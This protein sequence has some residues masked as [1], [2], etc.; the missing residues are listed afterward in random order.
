MSK[1]LKKIES[2]IINMII[3]RSLK[4]RMSQF[5]KMFE[6]NLINSQMGYSAEIENKVDNT[7][8]EKNMKM[9]EH[10]RERIEGK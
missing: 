8:A 9:T 6:N 2:K 10:K 5:S 3:F 7:K 4:L 1:K